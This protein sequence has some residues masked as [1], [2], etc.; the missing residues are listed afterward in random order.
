MLSFHRCRIAIAFAAS[1]V[2]RLFL[3]D[4]AHLNRSKHLAEG[5]TLDF[6]EVDKRSST[7]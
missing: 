5:K 2:N 3:G 7:C 1:S 6:G 4:I